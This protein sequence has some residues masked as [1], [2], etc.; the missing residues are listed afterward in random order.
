M[1]RLNSKLIED[2]KTALEMLMA[3]TAALYT[4]VNRSTPLEEAVEVAGIC[5]S[6]W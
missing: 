4:S 3:V 2:P 6:M 1:L 5:A